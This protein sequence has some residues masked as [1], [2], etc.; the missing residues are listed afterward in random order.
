MANLPNL[1]AHT[2]GAHITQSQSQKEV[3][4]NGLDDLLD[5]WNLL[6]AGKLFHDLRLDQV[7]GLEAKI[8]LERDDPEG[9]FLVYAPTEEPDYEVDWL[10]DIRS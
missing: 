7:G 1:G 4:S 2:D 5:N 3:T 8:R 6:L 9:R 10:L